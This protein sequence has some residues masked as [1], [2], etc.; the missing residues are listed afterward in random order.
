MGDRNLFDYTNEHILVKIISGESIGYA[1]INSEMKP[2]MPGLLELVGTFFVYLLHPTKGST[3]FT[4]DYDSKTEKWVP[5]HSA[6]WI[7]KKI[8]DQIIASLQNKH[9]C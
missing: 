4:I 9:V 3:Y 8:M 2:E 5:I 1:S 6:D 7:E